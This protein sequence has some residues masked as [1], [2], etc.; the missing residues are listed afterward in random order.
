MEFGNA[1]NIKLDIPV[2]TH[3]ELTKTE[4]DDLNALLEDSTKQFTETFTLSRRKPK[5]G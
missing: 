2:G 4:F 5:S 1:G 3:R